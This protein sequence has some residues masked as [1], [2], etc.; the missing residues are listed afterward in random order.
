LNLDNF[1]SIIQIVLD[2][3]LINFLL[4]SKSVDNG[5]ETL[6]VVWKMARVRSSGVTINQ[7]LNIRIEVLEKLD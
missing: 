7:N 1:E 3:L 6:N 5:I 2:K 4:V